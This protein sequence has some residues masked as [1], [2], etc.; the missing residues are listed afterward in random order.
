MLFDPRRI[1]SIP[2]PARGATGI[3]RRAGTGVYISIPAPA[4]GATTVPKGPG[5]VPNISIPA[6]ARGATSPML[7]EA[8]VGFY[9]NS[10]PCERG[11]ANFSMSRL[12]KSLF[13]FPPLREGRPAEDYAAENAGIFQFPPLREGRPGLRAAGYPCYNFNS[14]PCERGDPGPRPARSRRIISIPAPARGAT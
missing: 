6:P 7:W 1:I 14:R 9:F 8:S 3:L 12:S 10:R 5:H 11:D 2:A 13:H 4:R